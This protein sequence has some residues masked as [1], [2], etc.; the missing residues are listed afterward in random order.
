MFQI[1]DLI[2]LSARGRENIQGRAAIRRKTGVILNE[3]RFDGCFR[4]K[5]DGLATPET[6]HADFICLL[7]APEQIAQAKVRSGEWPP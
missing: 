7:A 4:V 6:L 2:E 5:W 3:S 1:G